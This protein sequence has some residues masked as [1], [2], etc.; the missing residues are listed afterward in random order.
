[1]ERFDFVGGLIG[2]FI[3]EENSIVPVLPPEILE[4]ILAKLDFKSI[5]SARQT[6][7][8]WKQI[9]DRM[10]YGKILRIKR[11]FKNEF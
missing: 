6:C 1:M 2:R 10:K 7:K 9:L 3:V 5:G 8:L 11:P 4:K